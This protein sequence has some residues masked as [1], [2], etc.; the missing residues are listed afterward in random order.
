MRTGLKISP[1][2]VLVGWVVAL[3]LSSC[4][5]SRSALVSSWKEE[6]SGL[7]L[8]FTQEGKL[9]LLPPPPVAPALPSAPV[10]ISY[11]FITD[12]SIIITP[13]SVLGFTDNVAIPFTIDG[14]TLTM[15]IS[16]QNPLV[17]TRVK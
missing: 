8:I 16:G 7:T 3:L 1:K 4:A 10:E 13:A 11:Q 15:Q 6:N 17:L 12:S 5:F 14:D 9:R 2:I